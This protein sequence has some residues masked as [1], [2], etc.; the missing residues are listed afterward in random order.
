MKKPKKAKKAG[1]LRRFVKAA[2]ARGEKRTGPSRRTAAERAAIDAR[3]DASRRKPKLQPLAPT[4]G[5]LVSERQREEQDNL[6]IFGVSHHSPDANLTEPKAIKRRN[7]HR[8]DFGDLAALARSIDERG[9]L[10]SPIAV[11][12]DWQLIDGERRL[13]AWEMSRFAG[14][15]IPYH[16]IDI[17]LLV[18]G[19]WDANA[20]RKDF[21]PSE[22]VAIKRSVED[23]MRKLAKQQAAARPAES[24]PAP[25]RKAGKGATGRVADRVAAFTGVKRRTLEKAERVVEAAERDPARYGDLKEQ[26]D[27][28]GKVNA[29]HKKLKV[30]QAKAAIAAA[31]P[32][33]PMNAGACGT[34][35]IDFPW[36]GEPERDQ[37]ALD[38]AGR[39][40]RPYP[41]MNH[42]SVCNFAREQIAPK[43]PAKV[44]VWLWVTNFI[45]VRGY[46][47]HVIAAL[48]FK[49]EQ[50]C[51]MLTWDKVEIGRGAV[52]RDQTEHAILLTRGGATIDVFGEDP[53][54]TLIREPR[55]ENSRKPEAFWRLAER[56]T[57]ATRYA[58]IFSQ[59]GEGE[60]WD[61]HGDQVG[62]YAAGA[63]PAAAQLPDPAELAKSRTLYDRLVMIEFGDGPLLTPEERAELERE[64]LIKG[65]GAGALNAAGKKR[66]AA[67][68]EERYQQ[69]LLPAL[70]AIAA[71]AG[72][73]ALRGFDL[74]RLLKDKWIVGLKKPRLTKAAQ[75][76]LKTLR[77][78][79]AEQDALA[80]LPTEIDELI[81]LYGVTI[82]AHH[83][84]VLASDKALAEQ[85]DR[86]LELLQMR[87]NGGTNF[88]MGTDESPAARLRNENRAPI[89]DVPM[90]AQDGLFR[91][92]VDGLPVIVKFDADGFFGDDFEFYA[93]DGTKG[94]FSE[95][96]FSSC[97]GDGDLGLGRT[98]AQQAEDL[99]REEM[100]GD[101]DW[102]KGKRKP[103]KN[104]MPKPETWYRMPAGWSEV[105]FGPPEAGGKGFKRKR[106]KQYSPPADPQP[107][108]RGDGGAAAEKENLYR[109]PQDVVDA[110]TTLGGHV[111][112]HTIDHVDAGTSYSVAT[113]QCKWTHRVRRAHDSHAQQDAAIEAHW[114]D[115]LGAE[116]ADLNEPG[117]VP[118]FLDR[119]GEQA[120]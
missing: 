45:L 5:K 40:F 105:D 71:G 109:V 95:S 19:E 21:T 93:E 94:F 118:P 41:E 73:D 20:Q 101:M 102:S 97:C 77:E 27:R 81:R 68:R 99:L 3:A 44:S 63:E 30:R 98:V 2:K 1:G 24:R 49:P 38:A 69:H 92:E 32:P 107:A 9:G 62:K 36:A 112:S 12:P 55:R 117:E 17:D 26:M 116:P 79:K 66:L 50:A 108:D 59:G 90:W 67:L 111:V 16:T 110:I 10:I 46:V 15:P 80:A 4:L 82:V 53:P 42:K 56:L 61:G 51:T 64:Q 113:C 11:T 31:P 70:E 86:T 91:L 89:G 84:A 114:R 29:P 104:G 100:S 96:G 72:E 115:A 34:W 76:R 33:L 39:S 28:T 119:R 54:T 60:L 48:G 120:A 88:G 25:G 57:P 13:R 74:P 22:A 35:V 87:A 37:A 83:R 65:K 58:S 18:A 78:E 103:W 85:L 75:Q 8:T 47:H 106:G 43:L 52:L 14:Q 23:A 6:R 7:R